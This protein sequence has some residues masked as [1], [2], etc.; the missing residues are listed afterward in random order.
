MHDL[1]SDA[2]LALCG[3]RRA[4]GFTAIAIASIALGI[5]ANTAIF[6][7]VDQ[8]LLRV[9]PVKAPHQLVQVTLDGNHYGNNWGDLSELSYPWYAALGDQPVFD[10]VFGRFG[11]K[12]NVGS[13]GHTEEAR[14]EIVTGTYFPVLGVRPALGRLLSPDDDRQRLGHPVAVLSHAY[15]TSRFGADPSVVNRSILVNG[16]PYTVVGVAQPGFEGIELGRATDIFV[17]IAMKKQITPGWDGLDERLWRWVRVFGRLKPGESMASAQ[18]GLAAW[19]AAQVT[20]DLA[21]TGFANAGASV[22][23]EYERNR[24]V[25]EP[26]A[27]GHSNFRRELTT[28]LLV[29]MSI[30][31]GVLVIACA[32]VANLLLARAA[33]R[34]REMAMRLAIGASRAQLVRQL[35]I[36][37][38]LLAGAGGLAGLLISLAGAPLVL[39]MLVPPDAPMPVSTLPDFRILGFAFVVS[40][41][42][43][44]VFGLAPAF[45][46]T[47]L[48]VTSALKA[49]SGSVLGGRAR[50]RKALVASQVAVSLLLLLASGLFIRTLHNLT[51][52]NLGIKTNRLFAFEVNPP[53]AGYTNERTRQFAHSLLDRLTTTPGIASAGIASERILQS[54]QWMSGFSVEGTSTVSDER[55]SARCNSV[56]PAYFKT[57]GV[58]LL[59]GRDFD[60]RD[61]FAVEPAGTNGPSFRSAIVNETFAKQFFP[62]GGAVGRHIGFGMDPGTRL[63]IEIVGVVGDFKYYDVRTEA[64]RQVFFPFFEQVDGFV[65]YTRTSQGL[66]AAYAAA[67][68]TVQQ[69]DSNVPITGLRSID[70]DVDSTLSGERMMA[71]MSTLFGTLA[72]LLAV[73][74]LYGVMS[75]TVA[76]RTREIGVRMALGARSMDV[77]WMV[78]REAL[79]IAALGAL[80]GAPLAWWLSRYVE[81]QL[82]GV[83]PTDA[84]TF[85]L[86]VLALAVVAVAAGLVPSRR[87]S[88][89]EPM[90]ALRYE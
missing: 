48:E 37:S 10:G 31:A 8:V 17:P 22:R 52:V 63:D 28:P 57:M 65:V 72:T 66:D 78:M 53:R 68:R 7:L 58:G 36:E 82:F 35:L 74:G 1:L 46:S 33:G 54:Y 39:G 2:R 86:V 42:T 67:R 20:T 9:L 77:A 30:A 88:K 62:K 21:T 34:Q 70:S 89:V 75:F 29:L 80:L 27:Q 5:G 40:T 51:G 19:T 4:P 55:N 11:Y 83:T 41:L 23:K 50:L 59:E 56:S 79:A 60:Q 16:Q 3:W 43:G 64:G 81:S 69:I 49:E 76:R 12:I 45:Q 15:W 24:V 32:N 87:A 71:T 85:G 13:A 18:A 90:T 84:A 26:A 25:L 38:L 44:V 14:G 73:V 6:T 47:S 61:E